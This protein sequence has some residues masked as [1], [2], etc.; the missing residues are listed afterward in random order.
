MLYFLRDCLVLYI[1]NELI[2]SIGTDEIIE[3][4]DLAASHRANI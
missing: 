1:E 3:A 2:A 4:Y